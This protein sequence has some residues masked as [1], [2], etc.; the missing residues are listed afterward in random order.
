MIPVFKVFK[1]V[2]VKHPDIFKVNIVKNKHLNRIATQNV[3]QRF[4]ATPDYK[5]ARAKV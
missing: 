1:T 3:S 5:I 2:K 4:Q